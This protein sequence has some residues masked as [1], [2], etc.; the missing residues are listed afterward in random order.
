MAA[1]GSTSVDDTGMTITEIS[2]ADID[3]LHPHLLVLYAAC[4]AGP[5]WHE[6][7]RDV[8]AYGSR[9]RHWAERDGFTGLVVHERS[10]R[11]TGATYGWHGPPEAGGARLPGIAHEWPF[12]VGDLMV[13]PDV[14]RRG[15]GRRLLDRLV[16]GRRPALLLTH[17]ASASR[18]LYDTAGWRV[19]STVDLSGS[20]GQ[21]VYTLD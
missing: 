9:I 15:L 8:A 6:D 1:Q 4:F 3:A 10:G 11:L 14:Q 5:P 12:H 13:H 7:D 20:P 18:R 21:V 19:T 17:P 16:T 2:G